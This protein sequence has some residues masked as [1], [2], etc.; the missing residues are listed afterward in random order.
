MGERCGHLRMTESGS[1]QMASLGHRRS[2]EASG[3]ACT[4]SHPLG[5]S[6]VMR[7]LVMGFNILTRA[8][9]ATQRGASILEALVG[10]GLLG[11]VA[12]A[13]LPAIGTGL[14]ASEKVEEIHTAVA[15]ARTQVIDISSEL[16][17]DANFYPVT[18]PAPGEYAIS[19][20]VVDESP[21]E[22]PNT[23]QRTIVTVSRGSRTVLVLEDYKAKLS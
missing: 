11:I 7:S 20:T 1:K 15:L 5:P 23:L 16:Y 9:M 6:C 14:V 12:S 8:G 10:V 22:Y 3:P 18:V 4:Q 19:I 17:S 13:F 2:V 21:P